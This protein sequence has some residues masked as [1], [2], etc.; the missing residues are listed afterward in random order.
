[1]MRASR[2][3]DTGV[4]ANC[5]YEAQKILDGEATTSTDIPGVAEEEA[6]SAAACAEQRFGVEYESREFFADLYVAE[7]IKRGADPDLSE[8]ARKGCL[9][10]LRGY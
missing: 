8:A 6:G 10:G 1:M 9:R 5:I 2:R 4:L 7:R 3:Q